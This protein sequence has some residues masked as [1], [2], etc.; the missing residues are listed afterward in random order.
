MI[1]TTRNS[2]FS[3]LAAADLSRDT[4]PKKTAARSYPYFLASGQEDRP[5]INKFGDDQHK[6]AIS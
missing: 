2:I 3:V 6:E 5:L 4:I 1:E